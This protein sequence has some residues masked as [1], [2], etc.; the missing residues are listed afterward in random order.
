MSEYE[1]IQHGWDLVDMAISRA[2]GK[3]TEEVYEDAYNG[4]PEDSGDLKESID[5]DHRTGSLEGEVSVSA[6]YWADVEY[7]TPPHV[8]ETDT[9]KVLTDGEGNFFGKRVY[10]PGTQANPFM[11]NALYK[12]RRPDTSL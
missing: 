11:R 3:I 8:I 10:H 9:K 4:A 5:K 2:V 1:E 6:D 7:G 12:Q